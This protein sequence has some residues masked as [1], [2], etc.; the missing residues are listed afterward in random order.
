MAESLSQKKFAEAE[1]GL[2]KP[3]AAFDVV[4]FDVAVIRRYV[5]DVVSFDI[6][7]FDVMLSTSCRGATITYFLALFASALMSVQSV[8]L[9]EYKCG[10]NQITT[11][12]AYRSAKATCRAHLARHRRNTERED[13]DALVDLSHASWARDDTDGIAEEDK[14][15]ELSERSKPA[16]T[17]SDKHL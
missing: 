4:S 1:R 13:E 9:S 2:Q 11:L 6:V 16:L 14:E 17:N 7:S 8:S 15:H 5:F 10:T 12:I 3:N